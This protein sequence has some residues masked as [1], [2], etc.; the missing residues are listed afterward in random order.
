MRF[1]AVYR[2]RDGNSPGQRRRVELIELESECGPDL[3]ALGELAGLLT[4]LG[5]TTLEAVRELAAG[6]AKDQVV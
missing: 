4:K 6:A 2:D 3:E 1:K 5:G